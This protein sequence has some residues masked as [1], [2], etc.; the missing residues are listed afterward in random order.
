M[1]AKRSYRFASNQAS[2]PDHLDEAA[3][4]ELAAIEAGAVRPDVGN[5]RNNGPELITPPVPEPDAAT[6]F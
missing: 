6:L 5:V 3:A 4:A 1:R 2:E